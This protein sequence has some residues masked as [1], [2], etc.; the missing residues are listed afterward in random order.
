MKFI[1]PQH[2]KYSKLS[3]IA[4]CAVVSFQNCQDQT[5]TEQEHTNYL[6]V[7]F[8]CKS[9][10]GEEPCTEITWKVGSWT[11]QGNKVDMI[12][13]D[14]VFI[15]YTNSLH[16]RKHLED[17][18]SSQCAPIMALLEFSVTDD[19]TSGGARFEVLKSGLS[20][21]FEPDEN[22]NPFRNANSVA[23]PRDDDVSCEATI[24]KKNPRTNGCLID[25]VN[26]VTNHQM[27]NGRPSEGHSYITPQQG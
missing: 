11:G 4:F 20:F 9:I 18:H 6:S 15:G 5:R 10:T 13:S 8:T 1:S 22:K 24:I 19:N 21:V 25:Q 3:G 23:S 17:K 2:W 16:L 26:G 27:A 14:H 7:K 12:E